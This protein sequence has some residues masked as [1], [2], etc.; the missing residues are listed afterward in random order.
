[1]LYP[2]LELGR[3][4]FVGEKAN[5]PQMDKLLHRCYILQEGLVEE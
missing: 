1:M 3:Q 2:H 5:R 4:W